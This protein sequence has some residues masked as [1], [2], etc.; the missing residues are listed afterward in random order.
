MVELFKPLIPEALTKLDYYSAIVV[1]SLNIPMPIEIM[2]LIIIATI[3]G[4][5][6]G[7]LFKWKF[8]KG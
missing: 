6:W 7:L 1:N 4:L 3:L 5:I 2:S 8:I